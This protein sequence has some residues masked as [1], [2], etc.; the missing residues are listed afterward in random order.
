MYAETSLRDGFVIRSEAYYRTVWQTFFGAGM[1]KPL[2]AEAEGEAVA[3]LM[4]FIFK[5]QAWYI[6][7]MSRDL[8]RERMPNYLLQWEAM[9]AA[10]AAGCEVYDLWGSPDEFNESD[11]MWGVYRFKQGLGAY[12]VRSI[13]AWDLPIQPAVYRLYTQ[14][15]PRVVGLMRWRGRRQTRREMGGL[16][17]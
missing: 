8:H 11:P 12:E 7:G 2:I 15:L 1:L 6:Y 4:L 17:A 5:E 9:R 16:G 10:K 14:V 13:G 3:G